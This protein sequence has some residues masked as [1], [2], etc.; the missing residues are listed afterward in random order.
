MLKRSPVSNITSLYTITANQF[1]QEVLSKLRAQASR[2]VL[3][4][5][6]VE[7]ER[8]LAS[9]SQRQKRKTPHD[10][11]LFEYVTTAD[12]RSPT[13]QRH[14]GPNL[15]S[16][17]NFDC[18]FTIRH[19]ATV[20]N[21]QP[22]R[23]PEVILQTSASR[24]DSNWA[25]MFKAENF[26][27]L[28]NNLLQECFYRN[29]LMNDIP[30]LQKKGFIHWEDPL[31]SSTFGLIDP[32]PQSFW[33]SHTWETVNSVLANQRLRKILS[34]W[35][36]GPCVI[37]HW[38]WWGALSTA[39][40]PIFLGR[41]EADSLPQEG[42]DS[43]CLGLH[44]MGEESSLQYYIGSHRKTWPVTNDGLWF[45]NSRE[46]LQDHA[47]STGISTGLYVISQ[48]LLTKANG[49]LVQYLNPELIFTSRVAGP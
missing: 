31:T 38:T 34:D 30:E 27:F 49:P 1:E 16:T 5:K 29:E 2:L 41:T 46:A 7:F 18:S 8:W 39:H 45:Q 3:E 17:G 28:Q 15:T 23:P 4:P 19:I 10:D 36:G 26:G 48:Y 22:S 25:Q 42:F 14:K 21:P 9:F 13:M 32:L 33:E 11:E 20:I 35:F 44:I 12:R 24:K 43:P 47:T 6:F 37:A 40:Q